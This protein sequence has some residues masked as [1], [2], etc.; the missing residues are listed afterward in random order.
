N[1][2]DRQGVTLAVSSLSLSNRTAIDRGGVLKG[3]GRHQAFADLNHALA[4][5]EDR[6][7]ATAN[8]DADTGV[9]A[10]EKWLQHHLGAGARAADLIAYLDRKDAA[11]SQV[12]YRE[13]EPADTVDFVAAGRL[14]IDIATSNGGSLRVRHIMTHAVVG[15][16]GFFRRSVRSATVSA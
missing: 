6:L 7:L 16:M 15:E 4:W 1:F 3:K 14:A 5:C 11:E 12:L 8:P 2:C 13:G 10:F 9:G